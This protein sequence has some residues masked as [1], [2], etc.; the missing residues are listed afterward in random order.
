SVSAEIFKHRE[1][2]IAEESIKNSDIILDVGA[3]KGFFAAYCTALNSKAE[4]FCIE[5]EKNNLIA[6]KNNKKDNKLK[7]VTIIEA[8]LSDKTGQADLVVT[9]D[10]HNHYLD[11]IAEEGDSMQ[12]TTTFNFSDLLKEYKI[13]SVS[14]LK[15]DIEGG[16]YAVFNGLNTED[17]SKIKNIV[18]EYHNFP[19][20]NYKKIE[21]QLRENGFGV[22]VFPSKFDKTMG[23]IFANNKRI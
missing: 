5:P 12:K 9:A 20:R 11:I 6:L 1:Y 18:M 4:I 14:L 10:S 23:F 22:Q 19:D 3:H 13:K 21:Q 2:R 8:A 15:M 16:E 7:N 17:F